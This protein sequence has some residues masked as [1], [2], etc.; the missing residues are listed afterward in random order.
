MLHLTVGALYH[1]F[2]MFYKTLRWMKVVENRFSR[3][4][5]LGVLKADSSELNKS[6][7]VQQWIATEL[8][9]LIILWHRKKN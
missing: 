3:I 6:L 9:V 8:V 5:F 2:P 1:K 7:F 4:D